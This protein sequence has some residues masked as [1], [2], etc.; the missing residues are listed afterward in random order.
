MAQRTVVLTT[1]DL[2]GSEADE[3][4]RFDLDGT[5]YEIDLNE[6]N[7]KSLRDHLGRYVQH[8]RRAGGG[9]GRGRRRGRV[10]GRQDGPQREA[11]PKEVRAWAQSQGIEVS[12]RGRVP[13]DLVARFQEA[14]SK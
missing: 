2:D 11:D 13:A 5:E 3:T 6:K 9:S 1:D 4:V 12:S 8:A 14:T 7:A 10:S